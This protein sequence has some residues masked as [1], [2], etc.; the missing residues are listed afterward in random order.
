M[1]DRAVGVVDV[2]GIDCGHSGIL[3][4][5]GMR[6][7]FLESPKRRGV[8]VHASRSAAAALTMMTLDSPAMP[9]F[10]ILV[11]T[12]VTD[13]PCDP[14]CREKLYGECMALTLA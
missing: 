4:G 12:S 8:S 5:A 14:V 7:E 11:S 1:S 6:R 10:A 3:R 9:S 13:M 2:F